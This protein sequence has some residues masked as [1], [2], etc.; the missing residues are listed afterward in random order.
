MRVLGLDLSLTS[1]GV[2]LPDGTVALLSSR[3]R[4][5]ERL[6]DLQDAIKRVAAVDL[7]VIEGYSMG[8]QRGSSGVAQALGELGGVV[9][10]ALFDMGVPFAEVPPS[11]LKKF[12][13]GKGNANKNEMLL[14]AAQRLGYSGSSNDG[15]DA[16]W[17]RAAGLDAYGLPEVDLPK[18]QRDALAKVDWPVLDGALGGVA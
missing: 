7:V 15:A 5:V 4:G 1:T 18:A 16:L 6:A 8:G 12:A 2:A 3:H 9:R 10:L 11:T 17:L 14:A 13:C